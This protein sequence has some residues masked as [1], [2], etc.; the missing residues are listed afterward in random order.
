MSI[1]SMHS[2]KENSE[3]YGNANREGMKE[4]DEEKSRELPGQAESVT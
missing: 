4:S 3:V 2:T 1:N